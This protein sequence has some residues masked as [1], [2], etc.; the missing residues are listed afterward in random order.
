MRLDPERDHLRIVY[1]DTYFEFPF[2][3]ARS[4]EFA[5]F[6]TFAVPSISALLDRT[7]EIGKRTQKRYDDTDLIL[8]EILE[9]GYDSER[10]RA[11]IRRM[12][13]LHHRF[14]IS[15][16]DYLYVMST[17]IFE[18]VRWNQRFGWRKAVEHEKLAGYY[19][20][21][22]L[23]RFMNIKSIPESYQEFE[24]FNREYEEDHFRYAP[25]N[26]R[27]ADANLD[28]F[29]RWFLPRNLL[30]LGRPLL[31]AIMDDPLLQALNYP[32]PSRILRALA[33]SSLKARSRLVRF[34]PER[35]RP[36]LRTRISHRSYPGGYQIEK[37][38]PREP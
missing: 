13:T 24:R 4:V 21:R 9:N 22:A 7:G 15:S 23:G 37:L 8:N 27:V 16:D 12:N 26:R 14:P 31:Y 6:R 18:P 29:L 34:L 25:S 35:K 33:A 17:F 20:W 5:L 2:D 36:K 32:R 11:A 30:P 1:L 19:Y 3:M 10:G 38:G 28:M